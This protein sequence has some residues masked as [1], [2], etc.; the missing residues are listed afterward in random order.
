MVRQMEDPAERYLG[1]RVESLRERERER[2]DN[3]LGVLA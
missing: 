3:A 1:G 2:K